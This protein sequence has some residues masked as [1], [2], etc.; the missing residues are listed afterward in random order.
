MLCGEG[1]AKF[2][3]FRHGI[4]LILC[5]FSL[6]D[7]FIVKYRQKA[8]YIRSRTRKS[9]LNIKNHKY[10]KMIELRH[11]QPRTNNH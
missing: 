10:L 1:A 8:L 2:G 7:K 5:R 4:V 6:W 9:V 3:I 11:R